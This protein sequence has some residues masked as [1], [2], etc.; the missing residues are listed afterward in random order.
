LVEKMSLRTL[1]AGMANERL[2]DALARRGY[3]P[4]VLGEQ[5]GVDPKT[6]Q[7]WVSQSRVPYPKYR[8]QLG[9]L[10]QE[11]E[12]WL[13]PGITSSER[14][15]Q[16]SRSEV[17]EVHPRRACITGDEWL[18]L[19]RSA[20]AFADVLVY[21]GLFLPEQTP[22]VLDVF[23]EKAAT[24]T[25]VRLLPGRPECAAVEL[26]GEEEG[27]G[28]QTVAAKARN[29][30][31]L[32]RRSLHEAPGVHVRLHRTTLYTSIY[33]SDDTMIANPH[34][35]GLPAAQAPAMHLRRLSAG[36]LFDTYTA[37]YDRVWDEAEPAWP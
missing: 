2:R 7:R 15:D 19:F 35:L 6:V 12:A 17:V 27:I 32:L 10:L 37:M 24:G 11:S 4:T 5:I 30:L 13:W 23:A 22:A 36:G 16:A 18:R 25:R 26:R 9:A 28:G 1:E 8:A 14:A 29:A 33:R 34:V 31:R 3:T 21:A 20:T